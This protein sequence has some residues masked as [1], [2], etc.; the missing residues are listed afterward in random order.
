MGAHFQDTGF[1]SEASF[2]GNSANMLT[3]GLLEAEKMGRPTLNDVE[4]P[5]L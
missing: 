3:E 4:M 5:K 2:M 1:N